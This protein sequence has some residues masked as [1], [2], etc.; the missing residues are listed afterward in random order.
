MPVSEIFERMTWKEFQLWKVYARLEPFPSMRIG[1]LAAQIERSVVNMA[2]DAKK[3]PSP[4]P[5]ADF[6]LKWGE[7]AEPQAATR[8]QTPQQQFDIIKLYVAAYT[9]SL[10]ER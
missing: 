3:H 1:A 2:R 5:L 9:N 7:D 6:V 8:F 10:P 4:F